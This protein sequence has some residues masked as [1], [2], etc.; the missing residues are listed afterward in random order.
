M[1]IKK[2]LILSNT[3]TIVIPF[4]I[5][6]I[7]AFLFIFVS[8]RIFNKD[9]SYD[10]FKKFIFIKTELSD[11]RSAIWKQNSGD[12]EDPQ[13]QQYLYQKLLNINGDL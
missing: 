3:I 10:N 12:I 13:F 8:S 7:A 1:N 11:T 9:I 5:T 2:R 4:V 6:I